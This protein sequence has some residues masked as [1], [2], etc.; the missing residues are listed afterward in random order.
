MGRYKFPRLEK[1][2]NSTNVSRIV[3]LCAC[4]DFAKCHRYNL[5]GIDLEKKG[6]EVLHILKD[7]SVTQ[8]KRLF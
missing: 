3:L 5:V 2:R 1:P 4:Y 8:E 6:Y 7:G